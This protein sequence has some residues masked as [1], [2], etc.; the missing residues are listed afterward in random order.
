MAE[1][2]RCAWC[3]ED[4]LYIEYHDKEWGVPEK[5]P[6]QLFERLVLE[7]MQAGLSWLT[8]LKKRAHMRE[9]FFAFDMCKLAQ[10]DATQVDQWLA[11]AGIIRH[12]GKLQA[13]LNNARLSVVRTDFADWLW[14]FAP[15]LN[16]EAVA[17]ADQVPAYTA[18]SIAMSKALKKAGYQFVGPRIC[19]AFM[20][21]VGM[22]N[23][24]IEGCWRHAPC[25][26]LAMQTNIEADCPGGQ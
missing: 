5:D 23:D 10:A 21:S 11:D 25:R 1:P 18:A 8:V 17:R 14:S 19:Y 16:L 6:Q 12:R 3:G 2:Q 7:G 9:V 20:Q 15:P 26:T 4:P 13:M 22:V 24:H